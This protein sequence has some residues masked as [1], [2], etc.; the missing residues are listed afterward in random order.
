MS[1]TLDLTVEELEALL[2]EKKKAQNEIREKGRKVYEQEVDEYTDHMVNVFTALNT[3]LTAIKRHGV[4]RGNKL[5]ADMFTINGKEMKGDQKSRSIINKK[6][7]KKVVI[8]YAEIMTFK[9]EAEVGITGI[10]EFFKSKFSE[11]SKEIYNLLDSLLI[12]NTAGEYDPRLL[13]KLRTQVKN[14]NNPELTKSF[15]IME[16]NQYVS[17]TSTYIRVYEKDTTGKWKDIVL[18]FSSL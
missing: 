8:E 11:R 3:Q 1:E 7:T 16:S 10:K 5:Y 4:E 14:I 13:S 18:Q 2:A 17:K 6:G 9:P 15:E 12:K